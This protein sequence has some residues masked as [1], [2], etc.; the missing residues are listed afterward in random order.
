[1]FIEIN[2]FISLRKYINLKVL[3]DSIVILVNNV[4]PIKNV[5]LFSLKFNNPEIITN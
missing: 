4:K 2:Y 5:E 3:V 1:M